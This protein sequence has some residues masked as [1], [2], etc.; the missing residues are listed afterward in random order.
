MR[1][2]AIAALLVLASAPA[3]SS[4]EEAVS[5]TKIISDVVQRIHKLVMTAP[6]DDEMRTQVK[7][8]LEEFVDFPE[9]GKLCLGKHWPE[10]TPAQQGEYL[11]AF[12][13]L[14]Q[15][16]YLRRFKRGQDFAVKVSDTPRLNKE[17]DRIEVATSITTPSDNVTVDVHYRFYK[18]PKGWKV[19]DIVVDEVSMM[20]NYRKSFSG[21]YARDGFAVLLDKMTK[22]AVDLQDGKTD[23]DDL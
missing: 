2:L 10:L 16:N 9:F 8:V 14:L 23:K 6:S 1:V 22:K 18:T 5:T 21:V 4:T 7:T 3:S 20:R 15:N 19:Y 17:G 11:T 13:T 12:R